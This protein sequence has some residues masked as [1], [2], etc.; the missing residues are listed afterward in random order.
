MSLFLDKL[1]TKIRSFFNPV[2]KSNEKIYIAENSKVLLLCFDAI[3]HALVS[4]VLI[5]ILKEKTGCEIDIFTVRGNDLVYKNND[6]VNN[7]FLFNGEKHLDEKLLKNNYDV[8]IDTHFDNIVEVVS[9]VPQI[10]AKH[11]IAFNKKDNELYTHIVDRNIN[12]H[13]IDELLLLLNVFAFDFSKNEIDIEYKAELS[14]RQFIVSFIIQNKLDTA[15][16]MIGINISSES[17]DFWGAD[18]FKKI[19]KYLSNYD[20]NVIILRHP[21]DKEKAE[22]V[23]RSNSVIFTN[24]TYSEFSAMICELDF[25][26][27]PNSSAVQIASAKRIPTFVLFV[28]KETANRWCPYN[29]N[30]DCVITE[31]DNYERLSYGNVLNSFIPF[32]E[33]FIKEDQEEN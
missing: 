13:I 22:Q 16:P 25:L 32:F 26:F 15:K 2:K 30:Y 18:R 4:T 33:S 10:K 28:K 24:N 17:N 6:K 8:L 3:E 31:N 19:V 21:I 23:T 20:V 12:L 7:V 14:A 27:T 29:F 9:I 11:K 5:K 1:K